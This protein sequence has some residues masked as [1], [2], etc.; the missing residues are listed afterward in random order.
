MNEYIEVPTGSAR[1]A[2]PYAV[3]LS[4]DEGR[5]RTLALDVD[6][7]DLAEGRVQVAA[8]CAALLGAGIEFVE[9]R[10]GQPG[11]RHLLATFERPLDAASV[12]TLAVGLKAIAPDLDASMLFNPRTGCIR[13]PLSP[14]RLGGFSE[15]VGDVGEALAVL[16]RGNPPE[17]F[18][19]LRLALGGVTDGHE[20][21][22]L[23]SSGPE[24]AI[25]HCDLSAHTWHLIR[26]GNPDRSDRSATAWACALGVANSGW[27]FAEFLAL[28]MDRHMRGLDHLRRERAG[29][30]FRRRHDVAAAAR[31]MWRRAVSFVARNPAR[32]PLD[33]EVERVIA[34]VKSADGAWGGQGGPS[35]RA[36]LDALL[37]LARRYGRVVVGA[38]VRQIAELAGLS[39]S[40]AS[41]AL[42]RLQMKGWVQRVAAAVGPLATEYRLTVPDGLGRQHSLDAR[43][44][45]TPLHV[46]S[47]DVGTHEGLGRHAALLADLIV[48]GVGTTR[49]LT[50]VT[51][52]DRR[53][54][55]RHLARLEQLGLVVE[56]AAGWRSVVRRAADSVL[57]QVARQL[58]V[59]GLVRRRAGMH[60][61]ERREFRWFQ[62]DFAAE[63]GFATRR[64]LRRVGYASLKD[65]TPAP[66]LVYP[67]LANGRRDRRAGLGL[68]RAGYDPTPAPLG[69]LHG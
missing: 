28:C 22:T 14:H 38:S 45:P 69:Q 8:L 20:T 53:T 6:C 12:R 26:N 19:R 48:D 61:E 43:L 67:L 34:A 7:A 27:E 37:T 56:G 55:V 33:I 64:G 58:R 13:P 52:M 15:I 2:Q 62:S 23:A 10:S 40:A 4:D 59:A 16:Q 21:A 36:A 50:T 9:A 5:F 57:G 54:V 35:C 51:G 68:V 49:E 46:R 29:S 47:H 39:R 41:T 32:S 66:T 63:R 42:H 17:A 44:A 60:E 11:R 30:G 25:R 18:E 3:Y 31:R 24:A 65:G 1:P